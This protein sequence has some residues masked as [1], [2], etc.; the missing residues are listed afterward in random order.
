MINENIKNLIKKV[1]NLLKEDDRFI[2]NGDNTYKQH[3]KKIYKESKHRHKPI[4]FSLLTQPQPII[5]SVPREVPREVIRYIPASCNNNQQEIEESKKIAELQ[6]KFSDELNLLLKK[7]QEIE[8]S[9]NIDH[10][11]NA[12]KAVK[13][14]LHQ[15]GN[16]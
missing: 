4:D 1:E 12:I 7:I 15:I 6:P 14:R 5:Q 8:V 10:L 2:D 11:N 16:L 3:I 13:E 9:L